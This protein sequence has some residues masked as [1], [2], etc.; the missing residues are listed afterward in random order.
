MLDLPMVEGKPTRRV[1]EYSPVVEMLSLLADR[2]S[3]LIGVVS[4]S[5]GIR[6]RRIPSAPRPVTALDRLRERRRRTTHRRLVSKMLPH[7]NHEP[8][9]AEPPRKRPR[10]P[11]PKPGGG[12]VLRRSGWG[13]TQ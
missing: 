12:D 10:P 9:P 7:K 13:G 6:P 2:I 1:S 8:P 5:R 11:A 4:A 3:E